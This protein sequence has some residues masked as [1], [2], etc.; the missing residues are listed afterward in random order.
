MVYTL[1]AHSPGL[2]RTVIMGPIG[3]SMHNPTL[4]AETTIG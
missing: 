4:M 1:M 3:H 2:T